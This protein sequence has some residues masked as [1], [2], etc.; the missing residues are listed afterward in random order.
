MN[1]DNCPALGFVNLSWNDLQTLDL[2][3]QSFL[4]RLNVSNNQL[5]TLD[6][7][8]DPILTYVNIA[9]NTLLNDFR[10]EGDTQLTQVVGLTWDENE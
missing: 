8:F 4:Q 6:V 2:S 5:M 7:S 3:D 10:T 9:N 1:V